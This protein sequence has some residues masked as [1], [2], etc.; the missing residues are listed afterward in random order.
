MARYD[1]LVD[2]LLR[3]GIIYPTAEI[4]KSISGFYEYG[5]VGSEIKRRFENYWRNWAFGFDNVHEI[6]GSLILPEEVFKGSGHLSHFLDPMVKCPKCGWKERADQFLESELGEKFEGKSPEELSEIIQLHNI[7]CPKCGA[8]LESVGAFQLM[9]K[10]EVGPVGDKRVAYLRPETAQTPYLNFKR[11]FRVNRQRLPL[12]LC[13]IGKAFRNEISPRQLLIRMREFTQA[14]LQIFF[15]PDDIDHHDLFD[16]VSDEEI[17]CLK[18]GWTDAKNVKVKELGLPE[19]YAYHLYKVYKFFVD[20]GL[21]GKVRMRELSD[22]EKAFYN[23]Y[24]WDVEAYFPSFDKWIEVA[25]V[26]YRT[27]HDLKG[28]TS[29]SGEDLSVNIQGR[30]FIPHVLELSF[31]VDRCILALLDNA[32]NERNEKT[33]LSIHPNL[34][35]YDVGVYPLVNKDK[36]PDKAREV[37]GFL[38]SMGYKAFYD[39]SGSIGRRYARADE[40]GIPFGVTVDFQTLEDNTVTIR[41]RDTGKQE[42]VSVDKVCERLWTLKGEW[43]RVEKPVER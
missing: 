14:E 8:S 40:I 10:L 5:S 38:R 25:G 27:D 30:K 24:H 9:F 33:V 41:L 42:R 4:Y 31:G 17:F 13:V 37:V 21:E 19:F 36:L 18:Q 23:R 32:F 15:D 11:E 29:Q 3:R 43:K 20:A 1:K 6:Q 7:K 39:Q 2:L 26:H 28:H 16:G 22:E 35:P 12:G 34:A